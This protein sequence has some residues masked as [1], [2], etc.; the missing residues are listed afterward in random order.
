MMSM[1]DPGVGLRFLRMGMVPGEP[2]PRATVGACLGCGSGH[3]VGRGSLWGIMPL[4]DPD[5]TMVLRADLAQAPGASVCC[6]GRMG[7]LRR[8]RWAFPSFGLS[9]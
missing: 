5:G 6:R 2:P 3:P 7:C 1:M 9:L 8:T 4:C